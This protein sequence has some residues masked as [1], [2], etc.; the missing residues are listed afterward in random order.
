[1]GEILKTCEFAVVE[2]EILEIGASLN[3]PFDVGTNRIDGY[4]IEAKFLN[5]RVLASE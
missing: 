3:D 2:G 1:M 5:G 4:V